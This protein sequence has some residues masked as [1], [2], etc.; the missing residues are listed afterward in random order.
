MMRT[1]TSEE[2][3]KASYNKETL[4]RRS[5]KLTEVC[6]LTTVIEVVAIPSL[7]SRVG[8]TGIGLAS[9]CDVSRLLPQHAVGAQ[10]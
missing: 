5:H 10:G 1:T 6:C 3:L 7:D 4:R 9:L 8:R 2:T